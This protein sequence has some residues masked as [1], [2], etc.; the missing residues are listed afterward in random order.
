MYEAGSRTDWYQ[1][2]LLKVFE[3]PKKTVAVEDWIGSHVLER[4][5]V[6]KAPHRHMVIQVDRKNPKYCQILSR[7]LTY[8]LMAMSDL[9]LRTP[10]LWTAVT[11]FTILV[12]TK[13]VDRH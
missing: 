13:G 6:L 4:G 8:I 10:S 3:R 2:D 1:V 12:V 5:Q 7:Y 11:A 9:P